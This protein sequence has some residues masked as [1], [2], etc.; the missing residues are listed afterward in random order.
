MSRDDRPRRLARLTSACLLALAVRARGERRRARRSGAPLPHARDAAL[1]HL[2]PS[3]RGAR[4]RARLAV[5]AEDTWRALERPL[6]V[7]PPPLTHVLLVDQTELANGWA[8]PA[9]ATTRSSI[10][11]AWPAGSDFIGNTDD[12]LRLA[13]THEFTHIVHLDRSE[14][15]ARRRARRLRPVPLAFPNLFLPTWQIEGL[16]TY[17]ESVDHRRRAAPRGRLPGRSSTRRRARAASSRSTASTAGSSTGP[18]ASRPTRTAS[19][20]TQWLA[21][22]F[23]ADRLAALAD[24]TARADAVPA[25]ARVP[26]RLRRAARSAL[27]ATTRRAPREAGRAV[28]RGRTRPAA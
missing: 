21:D 11:A 5:I 8:S 25:V 20:S 16:A 18:A 4:W 10:T 28:A 12:W 3:G 17:E 1:R 7:R 15:W 14:G 23:G 13:F 22:R 26:A 6:G 24:A 27:D 2:L 19:A 9:A